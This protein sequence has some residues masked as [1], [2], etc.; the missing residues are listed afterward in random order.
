ML[1]LASYIYIYISCKQ[2]Q[3]K[4]ARVKHTKRKT[5]PSVAATNIRMFGVPSLPPVRGLSRIG[6]QLRLV[7]FIYKHDLCKLFKSKFYCGISYPRR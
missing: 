4:M 1:T 5:V 3:V 6:Y 7:R 2:Q